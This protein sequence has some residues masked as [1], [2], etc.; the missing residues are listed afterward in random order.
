MSTINYSCRADVYQRD[1]KLPGDQRNS[2]E[3]E[4]CEIHALS[5]A[6]GFQAIIDEANWHMEGEQGALDDGL[7]WKPEAFRRAVHVTTVP[8]G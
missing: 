1:I 8:R 6:K 7:T 4:L 2:M 5:N 3:A